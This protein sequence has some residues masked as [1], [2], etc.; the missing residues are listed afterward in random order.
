MAQ[1]LVFVC[2]RLIRLYQLTLSPW[3]G[4]RCRFAPSC[5]EYA[6]EALQQHGL[7]KGLG[8]A[9]KRISR[10]HPGSDGGYDPVPEHQQHKKP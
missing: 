10:C 2:D 3:L 1:A 9:A 4:Q 5:S 6:R 7:I 8:L